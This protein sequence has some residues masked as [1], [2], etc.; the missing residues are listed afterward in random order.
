MKKKVFCA[1]V[2]SFM[3]AALRSAGE[4]KS[5]R[6]ILLNL[7]WRESVCICF[8]DVDDEDDDYTVFVL[9]MRFL[10]FLSFKSLHKDNFGKFFFSLLF[11][12]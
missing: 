1:C 8:L 3:L 12:K 11:P 5:N 2:L 7:E 4:I 6:C 10:D 9:T